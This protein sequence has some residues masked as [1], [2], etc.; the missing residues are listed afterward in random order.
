MLSERGLAYLHIANPDV[1]SMQKA[2]EPDS[3]A[4]RI[5]D[6]M[7][8]K[9]RGTF[10]IAGGFNYD[11]AE[12]WLRQ[13]K[14]DLVAFDR[15]FLAN[16]DLPERFFRR[17]HLNADDPSTYYGGGGMGYIDYLTLAQ[18]RGDEPKPQVDQ[19]WR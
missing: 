6:L 15:K 2:A 18:E 13:G 1:A 3:R 5:I 19:R 17:T 8:K 4:A 7:R 12:T 16:P 14:A 10:M 11:T 9:Y